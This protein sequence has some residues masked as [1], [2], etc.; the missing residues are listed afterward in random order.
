MTGL[1]QL[2]V[3]GWARMLCTRLVALVPALTG[4]PSRDVQRP[5]CCR[6][7]S[8]AQRALLD[9]CRML[10]V[11]FGPAW[12]SSLLPARPWHIVV[13]GPQLQGVIGAAAALL[14]TPCSTLVAGHLQPPSP[15]FISPPLHNPTFP[16][17]PPTPTPQLRW[18]ARRTTSSTPSTRCST[19]SSP[20]SCPLPSS[21]CAGAHD[22]LP[23]CSFIGPRLVRQP[24][25]LPTTHAPESKHPSGCLLA[26]PGT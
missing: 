2:E 15:V 13:A 26:C 3:K 11:F 21:R 12:A 7:L 6:R 5:S 1:L 18:S 22:L 25:W 23:C 24:A 19:W 14:C 17:P 9:P 16:P 10:L 20:S 4:E 8:A